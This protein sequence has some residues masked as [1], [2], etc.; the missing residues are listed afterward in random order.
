MGANTEKVEEEHNREH[1]KENQHMLENKEHFFL[2]HS[3]V[4]T[5]DGC[6][7]VYEDKKM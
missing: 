4:C 5:G 6:S 1:T 7:L 2:C 3:Q